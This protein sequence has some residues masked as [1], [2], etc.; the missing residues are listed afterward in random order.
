MAYWYLLEFD[1]LS[2][3]LKN[4]TTFKIHNQ[5]TRDD[6][7]IAEISILKKMSQFKP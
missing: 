7:Q 2:S 3:H 6:R 1:I 4:N 5:D